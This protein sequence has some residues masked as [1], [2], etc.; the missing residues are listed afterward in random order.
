RHP[1]RRDMSVGLHVPDR[2]GRRNRRVDGPTDT[3]STRF[4]VGM[5]DVLLPDAPSPDPCWHR[6]WVRFAWSPD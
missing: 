2:A 4:R 3:V 1:G 6:W 5:I